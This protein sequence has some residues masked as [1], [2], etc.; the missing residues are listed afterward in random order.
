MSPEV[1]VTERSRVNNPS[2]PWRQRPP[3]EDEQPPGKV[4]VIPVGFF[5]GGVVENLPELNA[6]PGSAEG[7]V[8]AA[9]G[10]TFAYQPA[11][12]IHPTNLIESD[13]TTAQFSYGKLGSL[14]TLSGWYG[15]DVTITTSDGVAMVM[16]RKV[17]DVGRPNTLPVEQWLLEEP[18][19]QS[20][21]SF[22]T[23][24]L[25][26]VRP[27]PQVPQG[28]LLEI[29]HPS[30]EP[31]T[32]FPHSQDS[33]GD[34]S[35][36]MG[37]HLHGLVHRPA[38]TKIRTYIS[39]H[40]ADMGGLPAGVPLPA[41]IRSFALGFEGDKPSGATLEAAQRIVEAAM[42]KTVQREIEVDDTDGALTFE[43]RLASKLLV[44]G[45]LSLDGDLHV[46]VYND[47]HPDAGAG[48]KEIWVDHL[49]QTTVK[50]LVA[51]F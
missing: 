6:P 37:S 24:G 1:I 8:Y 44:I 27:Y 34:P 35:T 16:T 47:Q 45:E 40:H 5:G 12:Y 33:A 46:D 19:I 15:D 31:G 4:H 7:T 10:G 38:G 50:D 28:G 30:S 29:E 51:L 39:H 9:E 36:I 49:P 17:A 13:D 11:H 41:V 26:A 20:A 25:R 2:A 14:L 42:E 22:F 18:P 23:K 32:P 21:M 43:L 48:L 3:L